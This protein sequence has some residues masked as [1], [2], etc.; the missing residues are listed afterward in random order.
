MDVATLYESPPSNALGPLSLLQK[1]QLVG[2]DAKWKANVKTDG[3]FH[4][5]ELLG[6]ETKETQ[7]R[8]ATEENL[9][10]W[11]LASA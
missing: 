11:S 8:E 4:D 10:E 3:R 2:F 7:L 9:K 1:M 6:L 5:I